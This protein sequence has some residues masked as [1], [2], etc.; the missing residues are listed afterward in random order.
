MDSRLRTIESKLNMLQ[1]NTNFFIEML[2]NQKRSV[3]GAM[4]LAARFSVTSTLR[5]GR[6]SFVGCVFFVSEDV[7]S[8]LFVSVRKL[9]FDLF[10][11]RFFFSSRFVTRSDAFVAFL[12]VLLRYVSLRCVYVASRYFTLFLVP[13]RYFYT[14]VRLPAAFRVVSFSLLFVSFRFVLFIFATFFLLVAFP[15]RFVYFW[16][17]S[18]VFAT[19]LLVALR[20]GFVYF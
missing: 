7:F 15:F 6:L 8:P 11:F 13:S 2:H 16:Y 18:F 14:T 3:S 12:F 10:R 4:T 17:V 1:Q 9:S 5:C 20:S 19:F